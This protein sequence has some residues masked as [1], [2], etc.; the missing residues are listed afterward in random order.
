MPESFLERVRKA[1]GAPVLPDVSEI[2]RDNDLHVDWAASALVQHFKK[3]DD[4][5]AYRLLVDLTV[6]RLTELAERVLQEEGLAESADE[7]VVN[8]FESLFVDLG[9]SRSEG[10]TYLGQTA[11]KLRVDAE[12]RVRD[13][14]MSGVSDPE[15]AV[16]W[17]DGRVATPVK[18]A[19]LRTRA[20]R[21]CFHRLDLSYR[22]V[23]RAKEIQGLSTAEIADQM[24][25]PL[26]ETKALLH[27]AELR[28]AEIVEEEMKGGVS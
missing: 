26:D 17:D 12:I 4:I 20:T 14:A 13:I 25:L 10:S 3:T 16:M 22:R 5:E 1:V 11:E 28:L 8:Y 24:S 15:G 9:S 2:D 18:E 19:D 6:E 27:E 7:L 21:I 23:L